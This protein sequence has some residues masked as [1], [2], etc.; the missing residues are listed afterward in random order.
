MHTSLEVIN[1]SAILLHLPDDHGNAVKVILG[2]ADEPLVTIDPAGH[3]RVS[4]SVGP[5]DPEVRKA[6]RD[7]TRNSGDHPAGKRSKS[8]RNWNTLILDFFRIHRAS[9][10]V[11]FDAYRLMRAGTLTGNM[12]DS[13]QCTLPR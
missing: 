5:G 13:P 9:A 3:I 2:G 7:I 6:A 4:P 10:N 8:R 11:F 1:R 12:H